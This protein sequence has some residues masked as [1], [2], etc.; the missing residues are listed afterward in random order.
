MMRDWD[1][2]DE[3]DLKEAVDALVEYMSSTGTPHKAT[4]VDFAD[5]VR[6]VGGAGMIGT[7]LYL[8]WTSGTDSDFWHDSG[9][10]AQANTGLPRF[11]EWEV[12][13]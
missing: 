6:R 10:V 13:A 1:Q 2:K 12:A 3:D 4:T 11:L 8:W 9:F 5:W 7:D